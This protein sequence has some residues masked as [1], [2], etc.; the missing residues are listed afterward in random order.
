MST[1]RGVLFVHSAPSALCPHVDWALSAAFGVP[2]HLQWK[3]QPAQRATYR[4]EYSWSGAAGTAARAA[5]ALMGWQRL[6]FELTED[7]CPGS[8][9]QRYSYTPSLGM[10]SAM[11]SSN[12]DIVIPEERLKTVVATAALTGAEV[13]DGLQALLGTAWDDELEVFRHAGEGAPVRWL[14]DAV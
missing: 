1:T 5:S 11:T 8:D 13:T 14:T 7:P 4:A 10:F 9:G 12:G 2:L 3:A 6:R